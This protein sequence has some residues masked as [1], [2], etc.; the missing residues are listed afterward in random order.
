MIIFFYFGTELLFVFLPQ[1]FPP[2]WHLLH[3]H[4]D[5]HWSVL[6]ILHLLGHKMQGMQQYAHIGDG[7]F[8]IFTCE[9]LLVSC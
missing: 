8:K 2:S 4:L 1:I 6:E 7:Q 3:L 9:L 5:T